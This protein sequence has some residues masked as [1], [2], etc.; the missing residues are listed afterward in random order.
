MR[1]PWL[2][3]LSLLIITTQ[4]SAQYF[5]FSQYNF[6]KQRINPATVGL[7]D[8]ASVSLDYRHQSTA[9]GFNLNSNFLD[10]SYPLISKKKIRWAGIG[11]T[12]MDDRSGQSALFRTQEVAASFAGNIR[13]AKFH[14]LSL[15]TKLLYQTRNMDM[16]GLYTGAQ[17]IPDRGFDESVSNGEAS[18]TLKTNYVSLNFGLH[19][20]RVDKKGNRTAY[21][22][23]SFFD[24]NKPQEDF[25]VASKLHTTWVG[26]AGVRVYSKDR[27]SLT[28][29]ILYTQS[30]SNSLFNVGIVTQYD[31]ERIGKYRDHLKL[32]TR[33]V[34]G[35]SA[36]AGIQLHKENFSVGI[37]YDFPIAKDNVANQGA[38]E[39]GIELRRLVKRSKLPSDRKAPVTK[40]V[41]PKTKKKPVSVKDSVQSLP[42]E[43]PKVPERNEVS[44]RLKHKQDSV[45]ALASAGKI[46][47]EPLI[48][49]TAVFHF[50]FEFGSAELDEPSLKYVE[51]LAQA[52]LDNP[53][54]KV[55]IVGHT[56]NV[57]SD[58]FN[59]KLSLYRAGALKDVLIEKG[60]EPERVQVEGKGMREPLNSNKTEADRA[61]NRRVVLTIL[62][63]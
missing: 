6:T 54:L 49:E 15:G 51:D 39:I 59:L 48:L 19:W 56:D 38:I 53:K 20:Q 8:Y 46:H 25:I 11:L 26:A 18:N 10:A 37:S 21:A 1:M 14:T 17:Y 43:E 34:P 63:D 32:L 41:Q 12:F 28:P 58:K 31:L 42:Q 35:R 50:N 24:F 29:E 4:V 61:L 27:I 36:I 47:H 62:Y 5:Q 23:F 16:D 3:L 9:G 2:F 57:G 22:G 55:T 60:I 13:L 30:T 44:E 40:P 33:Y 7:S 45:D 52:L